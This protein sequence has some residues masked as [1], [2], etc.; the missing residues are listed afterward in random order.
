MSIQIG[1]DGYRSMAA[2]NHSD[3]GGVDE[4][5]YEYEKQGD[6]VP[7]MARVRVWK[8]GFDH[9]SIGIAFWD[10]YAPNLENPQAFMW[11]K[12]PK[13][14]LAKCA[15]AL[16][17]R[18]A[19][20]DLADIYTDEEMDQHQQDFTP[21][22]RQIIDERGFAPSGRPVTYEAQHGSH[23]AAQR[24]LADKLARKAPG[25]IEPE[26]MPPAQPESQPAMPRAHVPTTPIPD[27]QYRGTVEIDS[28]NEADPILRGDIGDLLELIQKH[29]TAK[30]SGDWWHVQPRDVETIFQMCEQVGPYKVKHI[31]PK[32]SAG[33]KSAMTPA[34][35]T[36]AG[37]GSSDVS[38]SKEAAASGVVVVHGTIERCSAGMAGKA[39]VRQV[40]LLLVDKTKPTYSTFDKTLFERLDAGL[41]KYAELVIK[42]NG[43]Y[44]NIV[45]TRKIGSKEWGEDGVP[46]VQNR[47]REAGQKTLY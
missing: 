18:K 14:M 36:T 24:V 15:E 42:Q 22:G 8:K 17:L 27:R 31:L 11:K 47:D 16:A 6:K 1:I 3:F 44:W 13:H 12:M 33:Q 9:P 20:P 38:A 10:E 46:V 39:P 43:K 28:S 4:P 25:P 2:V 45:G 40:T 26:I 7:T 37:R 35:T 32:S 19:Y 23:E 41:G 29:C 5:E 21:S 34:G 30:W